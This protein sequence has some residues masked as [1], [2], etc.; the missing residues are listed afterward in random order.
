MQDFNEIR[1]I[2]HTTSHHERM[3]LLIYVLGLNLEHPE[4]QNWIAYTKGFLGE[5]EIMELEWC[6]DAIDTMKILQ[7]V[8]KDFPEEI[9][10]WFALLYKRIQDYTPNPKGLYH[11]GIVLP[12]IWGQ[13]GYNARNGG[14]TLELCKDW[15]GF[16]HIHESSPMRTYSD[17]KTLHDHVEDLP[18]HLRF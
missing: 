15:D 7:G 14:K 4:Y 12:E 17:L 11:R 18:K 13:E 8:D 10:F 1:S 2:C 5:D 9:P 16:F 6:L 3:F